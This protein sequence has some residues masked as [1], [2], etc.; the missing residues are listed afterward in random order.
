[1]IRL[2]P[3]VIRYPIRY[4]L[5]RLILFLMCSPLECPYGRPRCQ[6]ASWSL[7][8][9]QALTFLS[10]VKFFP[11]IQARINC[12]RPAP[13]LSLTSGNWR[14]PGWGGKKKALSWISTI[15]KV[16]AD[17]TKS[18]TCTCCL[19]KFTMSGSWFIIKGTKLLKRIRNDWSKGACNEEW[20]GW[21]MKCRRWNL[22][23][24]RGGNILVHLDDRKSKLVWIQ[25]GSEAVIST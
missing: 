15:V 13:F 17:D 9:P 2:Q 19:I 16:K 25:L 3:L 11:N 7:P 20:N 18:Y 21:M 5:T 14:E 12:Q 1:M 10:P 4:P 22:N 24:W 6:S 23:T 8:N